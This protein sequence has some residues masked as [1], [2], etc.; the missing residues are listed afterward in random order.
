MHLEAEYNRFIYLVNS[1]SEGDSAFSRTTSCSNAQIPQQE[2]CITGN[3]SYPDISVPGFPRCLTRIFTRFRNREPIGIGTPRFLYLFA[4]SYS[5]LESPIDYN[6]TTH[7]N[8]ILN[9]KTHA[10]Y[11]RNKIEATIFLRTIRGK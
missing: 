4:T 7:D 11:V 10:L 3:I 2:G 1:L 5:C 6:L 9:A 8:I